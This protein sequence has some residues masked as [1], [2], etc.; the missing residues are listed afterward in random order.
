MLNYF[1]SIFISGSELKKI[2]EQ[3]N[4]FFTFLDRY[5]YYLISK[6]ISFEPENIEFVGDYICV[7]LIF[8][9]NADFISISN[10]FYEKTKT[11]LPLYP[12]LNANQFI[13]IRLKRPYNEYNRYYDIWLM[14]FEILSSGYTITHYK[15]FNNYEC[16]WPSRYPFMHSPQEFLERIHAETME[17][18]VDDLIRS[19]KYYNK[20]KQE[21]HWYIK[22]M[23]SNHPESIP[24]LLKENI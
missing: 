23:M 18:W 3:Y 2:K 10:I 21:V 1:K 14:G 7:E 12:D 11:N 4:E 19:I 22:Y 24:N 8:K 20:E 13:G 15:I 17:N 6:D 9:R 16:R 5:G